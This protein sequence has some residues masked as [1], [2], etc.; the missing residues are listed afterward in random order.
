MRKVAIIIDI[1]SILAFAGAWILGADK[2][3]TWKVIAW[4][5]IAA[6][7]HMELEEDER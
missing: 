6:M 2:V 1:I 5:L 7:A 4:V 3:D